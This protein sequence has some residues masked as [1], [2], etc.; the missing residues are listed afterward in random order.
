VKISWLSSH[1]YWITSI[2]FSIVSFVGIWL[3]TNKL[4][5]IFPNKK[6]PISIAFFY[7]PTFLF[8]TSGISKES[9]LIFI[10]TM[11]L[12][13]FLDFNFNNNERS[14]I[15]KIIF[16]LIFMLLAWALLKLKYYYLI[17]LLPII[18]TFTF[19]NYL[20]TKFNISLFKLFIVSILVI[21]ISTLI[22]S[23]LHYNLR[24]DAVLQAIV[25][26]H[27]IMK[28]NTN[29][30]DNLLHF[31]QLEPTILSFIKNFPVAFWE[32]LARPYIW[33]NGHLYKK[34]IAFERLIVVVIVFLSIYF[35]IKNRLFI[36]SKTSSN[37]KLLIVC[38]IIYCITLLVMLS[39][40]AP[41]IGTLNRYQS[42]V[43]PFLVFM[44]LCSFPEKYFDWGFLRKGFLI[45]N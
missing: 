42:G 41:N 20:I 44:C 2:Y 38:N 26:N 37:I 16:L 22:F 8:W 1:H 7:L 13:I 17:V 14:K 36:N 34:T 23:F 43:I 12:F 27:D 18:L 39:Y 11:I 40:S 10:I 29:N 24:I 19:I 3:F 32:G 25:T 28:E 6:T 4:A 5:I 33:E 31:N 35:T 45:K 15:L 9:I 21:I 30:T